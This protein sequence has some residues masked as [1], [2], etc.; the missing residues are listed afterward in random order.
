MCCGGAMGTGPRFVV[1]IVALSSL[2]AVPTPTTARSR[3]TIT[4]WRT[5]T[6][7]PSVALRRPFSPIAL[8]LP[9]LL[10]RELVLFPHCMGDRPLV[11]RQGQEVPHRSVLERQVSGQGRRGVVR[12]GRCRGNCIRSAS[13]RATGLQER[14]CTRH[15]LQQVLAHQ[16][17][18]GASTAPLSCQPDQGSLTARGLAE[19][20]SHCGRISSATEPHACRVA[21]DP[22]CERHS[23]D[24]HWRTAFGLCQLAR[25]WSGDRSCQLPN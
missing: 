2:L 7:L 19:L 25:P 8:V 22:R 11:A 24:N 18:D 13:A 9:Q 10:G 16:I 14:P 5:Y 12:G 6:A 15:E 21:T 3:A 1:A 4:R 20:S 23:M 17:R